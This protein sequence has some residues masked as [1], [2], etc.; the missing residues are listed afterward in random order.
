MADVKADP[1]AQWVQWRLEKALEGSIKMDRFNK[2]FND[3][4]A[5]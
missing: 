1:R 5:M 2:S 4:D 3:A